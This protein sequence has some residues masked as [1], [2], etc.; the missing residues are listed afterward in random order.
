MTVPSHY[1]AD[2]G[3]FA[4]S[5]ERIEEFINNV[6]LWIPTYGLANFDHQLA[7]NLH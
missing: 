3:I 2:N 5:G 6:F 4:S 1:P 7:K